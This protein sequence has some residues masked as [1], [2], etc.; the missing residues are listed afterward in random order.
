[1]DKLIKIID[2]T[3]V[4]INI[5]RRILIQQ[6][7]RLYFLLWGKD[8]SYEGPLY[9]KY[10]ENEWFSI[11]ILITNWLIE[12]YEKINKNK[13]ILENETK[14]FFSKN[15]ITKLSLHIVKQIIQEGLI[16]NVDKKQIIMYIEIYEKSEVARNIIENEIEKLVESLY[17]LIIDKCCGYSKINVTK[18]LQEKSV[19]HGKVAKIANRQIKLNNLT[20]SINI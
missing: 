10:E 20:K 5:I 2:E 13:N 15:N 16:Y 8:N 9:D 6:T 19:M 1:M 7:E 14:E 18:K 17:D 4:N 11:T 12:C 3:P